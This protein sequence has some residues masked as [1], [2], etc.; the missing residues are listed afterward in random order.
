MLA[1]S[2]ALHV[3]GHGNSDVSRKHVGPGPACS[4]SFA[5]LR[6]LYVL[7]DN[8]SITSFRPIQTANPRLP[9][10]AGR[11]GGGKGSVSA[12]ETAIAMA[13]YSYPFQADA[14]PTSPG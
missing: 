1:F 9:E 14:R 4:P 8:L 6:L 13:F 2:E 5:R 10:D 7:A 3:R 11:Q 12:R